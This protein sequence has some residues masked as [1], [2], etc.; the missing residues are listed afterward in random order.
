VGGILCDLQKAFDCVN[1]KILLDKLEY[2]GI[3]GKFKM[4]IESYLTGRYQ[5]VI[6]GDGIDSHNGSKWEIIKC[7]VP[8]GSILGPLFFLLYINDLPKIINK[9]NNMVLFADDTSIII[10]DTNKLNFERNLNQTFRDI[11]TWFNVNLLT[12]NYNK[13][14]Y[15]E[16]R[17]MNYYTVTTQVSYDRTKLTNVTESK[18]L[19]LIIDSTLSWKQHIDYVIK[20]ISIACYALRN[21]KYFIPLDTLK[22]IYFAHIHT[23]ISYGI[24]IWG[25]SSCVNKVFILQK[26]AIRIIT[27]SRPKESCR[28]LFKNAKIMTFFSQYIYSLVLFTINND[29]LFTFNNEIHSYKTRAHSNL[30]LPAVNLTKYSKGAYISG[31]KAFNHLPQSIKRLATDEAS[32][33]LALK[34]FLYHHSFYSMREFYQH[35]WP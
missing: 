1:H 7:G 20:K 18:F 16:F 11:N 23:I 28:D 31:I 32:F 4:L 22:L 13:T 17:P 6:V 19:G 3:E 14:Q 29:H 9:N 35:N 33:K 8:Q 34:R 15:V 26:K 10:T 21:I 25:G 30:H 24:I 5:R 2:Y 12:L 27:N